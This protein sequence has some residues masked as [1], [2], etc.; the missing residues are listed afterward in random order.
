MMGGA[1]FTLL[2]TGRAGAKSAK[3]VEIRLAILPKILRIAGPRPKNLLAGG[4]KGRTIIV[5]C[6]N[7]R[8]IWLIHPEWFHLL[9][10][11]QFLHC[12]W[13]SILPETTGERSCKYRHAFFY[14]EIHRQVRIS[15]S[16]T[17]ICFDLKV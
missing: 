3:Q 9:S 16:E 7:F 12:N 8:T 17:L 4:G 6:D 13:R 10:R 5:I 1:A 11:T 2:K 15:R 14:L